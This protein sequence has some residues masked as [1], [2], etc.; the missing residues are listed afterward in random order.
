MRD[1]NKEITQ[2]SDCQ[3]VEKLGFAFMLYHLS[4]VSGNLLSLFTCT[5]QQ[6]G[7]WIAA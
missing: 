2:L 5:G 1:R 6:I 4:F 3:S 7:R